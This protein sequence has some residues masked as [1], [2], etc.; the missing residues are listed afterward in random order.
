MALDVGS[1][2]SSVRSAAHLRC[3]FAKA[4]P[5]P[6]F[7]YFSKAIARRSLANSTMT[8]MTQGLPSG[9]R[10]TAGIVGVKPSCE[11]G[12]EVRVVARWVRLALDYVDDGLR[13]CHARCD[14]KRLPRART[15]EA[16]R[17]RGEQ[18]RSVSSPD[19]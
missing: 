5:E 9:V 3:R 10:H 12:R 4:L 11:V 14:A 6:D 8:S 16:E 1:R 15:R 18:K 17:R 19:R 7:R 2:G 13:E